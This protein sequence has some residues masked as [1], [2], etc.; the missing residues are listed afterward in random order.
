MDDICNWVKTHPD[1]V[2]GCDEITPKKVF[3]WTC[4]NF[5]DNVCDYEDFFNCRMKG[6]NIENGCNYV[7]KGGPRMACKCNTEPIPRT[8][9]CLFHNATI[10]CEKFA[11]Y[12]NAI[13]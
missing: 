4:L 8:T 9:R 2:E 5:D 3:L 13:N 7:F 10:F 11:E 1:H 6:N 12:R